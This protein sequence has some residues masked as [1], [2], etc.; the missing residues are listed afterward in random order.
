MYFLFS[1]FLLAVRNTLYR[2][3]QYSVPS[4]NVLCTEIMNGIEQRKRMN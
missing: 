3:T 4:F 2:R 1:V